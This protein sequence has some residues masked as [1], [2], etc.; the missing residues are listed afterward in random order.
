MKNFIIVFLL[1][2]MYAMAEECELRYPKIE[3]RFPDSTFWWHDSYSF[4][5]VGPV[6]FQND[7]WTYVLEDGYNCEKEMVE[8]AFLDSN[9]FLSRE[10]PPGYNLPSG[11][12]ILLIYSLSLTKHDIGE[13]FKDEFL[14]W[15]QCGMLSLTYEEADSLATS[16]VE[17]L[18]NL[19][20]RKI[21]FVHTDAFFVAEYPGA[22]T[23][24]ISQLIQETCAET[25]ASLRR[26]KRVNI[27]VIFENRVAHI[28]EYLRGEKYSVFDVNGRV[29]Q[30]GVAGEAIR[31]P[32]IPSIL[33]IG[34][35]KPFLLK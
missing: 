35:V 2:T 5:G 34:N 18:N 33:K 28:P 1:L 30:K 9:V 22:N 20:K 29:V 27:G 3:I 32:S 14:H 16:L 12:N 10:I 13:V 26:V 8:K 25:S 6:V 11:M 4:F 7:E 31:M 24:Q 17:P 19:V 21:D 23:R 15:Q